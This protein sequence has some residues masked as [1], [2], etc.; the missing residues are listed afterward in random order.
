MFHR[1][2]SLQCA[3]AITTAPKNLMSTL[4]A[5]GAFHPLSICRWACS[6]SSKTPPPRDQNQLPGTRRFMSVFQ[7]MVHRPVSACCP[8]S[9]I[10]TTVT[11]LYHLYEHTSESSTCCPWTILE[12]TAVFSISCLWLSDSWPDLV[13]LAWWRLRGVSSLQLC[14]WAFPR[15]E[16]LWQL[17]DTPLP[18]TIDS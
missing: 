15:S 8:S 5:I 7:I 18:P 3:I 12:K 6:N 11:T 10:C 1:R 17:P 9:V 13:T 16:V 2:G 14:R 4:K